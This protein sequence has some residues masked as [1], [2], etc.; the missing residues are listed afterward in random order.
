M[1]AVDDLVSST[2][3][4]TLREAEDARDADVDVRAES[5]GRTDAEKFALSDELEMIQFSSEVQEAIQKVIP[6]RIE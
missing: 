5:H 6:S 2:L 4:L 3:P 1:T